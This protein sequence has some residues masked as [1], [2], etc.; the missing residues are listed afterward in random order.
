M[1]GR[2]TKQKIVDPRIAAS[3][4]GWAASVMQFLPARQPARAFLRDGPSKRTS[5][6]PKTKRVLRA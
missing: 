3:E 2:R 6:Q 1:R 5:R 4:I